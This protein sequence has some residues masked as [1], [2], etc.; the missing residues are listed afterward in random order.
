MTFGKEYWD[1]QI[2]IRKKAKGFIYE[3]FDIGLW[4][5][6]NDEEKDS[7]TK[8]VL[9]DMHDLCEEAKQYAAH[10][11]NMR[12]EKEKVANDL[13]ELQGLLRGVEKALKSKEEELSEIIEEIRSTEVHIDFKFISKSLN[14][15]FDAASSIERED[16]RARIFVEIAAQ[17]MRLKSVNKADLIEIWKVRDKDQDLDINKG[18]QNNG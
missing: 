10:T 7:I 2:E 16:E 8:R 5:T 18:E 1:Y 4:N 9:L 6:L 15:A 11:D 12:I 14:S 13:S 17:A 3:G